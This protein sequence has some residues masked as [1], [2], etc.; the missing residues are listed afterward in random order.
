MG[1]RYRDHVM[2]LLKVIKL[3]GKIIWSREN[4]FSVTCE[5]KSFGKARNGLIWLITGASGG[6][7]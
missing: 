7:L 2:E 6:F 4:M 5:I 3:Q 1:V